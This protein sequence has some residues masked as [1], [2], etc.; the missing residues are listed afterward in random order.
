MQADCS[1]PDIYGI[2]TE[3]MGDLAEGEMLQLQKADTCD[4]TEQDYLK[5]IYNKTSSL[6]VATAHSAAISVNADQ[7][8]VQSMIAFATKLGQAFQIK[9]DILDYVGGAVIGKPLGQD[10]QEQK[11]TMPLLGAFANS[12]PE[13]E[14]EIRKKLSNISEHPEHQEEIVAFVKANKGIDYAGQRLEKLAGEARE[15]LAGIPES[16]DKDYLMDLA[17]FV[18]GRKK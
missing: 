10:L 1:S 5:I 17:Y 2:F 16:K 4:T 18:I 7:E 6:F 12:G 8:K 11:I 13:K 15:A 3:T 14:A 9:D